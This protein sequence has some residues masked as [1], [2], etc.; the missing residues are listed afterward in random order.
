MSRAI[1][2]YGK[3]CFRYEVLGE[4]DDAILSDMEIKYIDEFDSYKN[5]YNST[6]G[7]EGV[8][9]LNINKNDIRSRFEKG[10]TIYGIAK[11]FQCNPKTISKLLSSTGIDTNKNSSKNKVILCYNKKSTICGKI[12]L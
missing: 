10:E 7:G 3:D 12:L 4:F 9:K 1:N 8:R 6:L 11:S 5:G 2:K